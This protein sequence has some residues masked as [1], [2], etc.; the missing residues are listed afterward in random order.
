MDNYDI[1]IWVGVIVVSL[2]VEFASM[3]VTSIWFS[4]GGLFALILAGIGVGL[5]IQIVVFIA[6]SILLILTVR[7]WARNKLLE[8]EE[9][10]NLD[11][12]KEERF[13]L[14]TEIT[15]TQQGTIKYNGIAWTAITSNGESIKEGEWVNVIEIKG[16]KLIVKKEK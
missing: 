9:K 1:W 4:V 5:E 2:L 16:N 6:I 11:L 12:M 10:T 15:E 7:K 13:K 14:I 8:S 3:D